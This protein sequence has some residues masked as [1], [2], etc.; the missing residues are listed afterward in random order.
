MPETH[1]QVLRRGPLACGVALAI[2][3]TFVE[4]VAALPQG[5]ASNGLASAARENMGY[6]NSFQE[7]RL[8][9][10]TEHGIRNFHT[11]MKSAIL[12]LL[13]PLGRAEHAFF[14]F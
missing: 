1:C 3:L 4:V 7:L 9:Q 6:C 11:R 2:R 5:R 14:D 8:T 10:E 12:T 13:S